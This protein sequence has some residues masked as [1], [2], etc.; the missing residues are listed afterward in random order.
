[1][2]ILK[3]LITSVGI[4]GKSTFLKWLTNFLT[5]LPCQVIALDL[6]YQRA[7]IPN[8]FD[9]GTIYLLEDVHGPTKKAVIPLSE[10]DLVLYM[11]PSWLTHLRFWLDRMLKW[12]E[13]GKFAWDA[14]VG[15]KGS[16][17]GN[18]KPRDLRNIPGIF[19]YFWN[20][21]PKRGKTIKEDLVTLKISGIR[22]YIIIPSGKWR[23]RAYTFQPL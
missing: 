15:K 7:E 21:F 9:S 23:K 6:D 5:N 19:K 22:T 2:I 1:V 3:I 12:Y 16:W 20:H 10:Y 8:E 14:D 4:T 13:N 11:Q 17:A 18:D